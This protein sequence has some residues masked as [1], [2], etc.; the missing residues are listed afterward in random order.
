M[1]KDELELIWGLQ[2]CK[3]ANQFTAKETRQNNN[4]NSNS[5]NNKC[6]LLSDLVSSRIQWHKQ[7]TSFQYSR[8]HRQPMANLVQLYQG[9]L[10]TYHTCLLK[11]ENYFNQLIH[12]IALIM[13]MPYTIIYANR[14]SEPTAL[15]KSFGEWKRKPRKVDKRLGNC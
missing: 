2:Q 9:Q 11:L 5:Y 14:R 3:S 4:N 13:Y 7:S 8:R 15:E 10:L 12:S 1:H 6:Q